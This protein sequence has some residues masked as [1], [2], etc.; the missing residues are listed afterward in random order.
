MTTVPTETVRVLCMAQT[1]VGENI[2]QCHLP[3]THWGSH[4]SDLPDGRRF[5]WEPVEPGV[6]YSPTDNTEPT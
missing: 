6:D 3:H 1:V 2:V 4:R 5:R